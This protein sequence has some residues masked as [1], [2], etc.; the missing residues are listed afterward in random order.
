MSAERSDLSPRAAG[1]ALAGLLTMLA[2]AGGIVAAFLVNCGHL[3]E[4]TPPP[5]ALRLAPMLQVSEPADRTAIE[6]RA[7]AKL[8]GNEAAMRRTA[9]A[10]WD[11]RP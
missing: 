1:W 5:P 9:A 11:G 6:A 3:R 2:L 10:G 7:R 4:P 8:A